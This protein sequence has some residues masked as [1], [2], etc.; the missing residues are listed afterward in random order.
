MNKSLKKGVQ[1][2]DNFSESES[3]DLYDLASS[4]PQAEFRFV[5]TFYGIYMVYNKHYTHW[6]CKTSP[7]M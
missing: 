2:Y 5:Y 1:T 4:R 3:G 6:L 7:V